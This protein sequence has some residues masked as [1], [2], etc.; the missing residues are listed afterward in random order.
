MIEPIGNKI[1]E[2]IAFGI[3]ILGSLMMLY[4]S[5]LI[6]HPVNLLKFVQPHHVMDTANNQQGI[7]RYE[8]DYCASKELFL[9]IDRQLENT[10]TGELWDVP[11]KFA[12]FSKGCSKEM[13]D[14][15]L[16]L[17]IDPGTYKLRDNISIRIN[18]LRTESYDYESESFFIG[19][20]H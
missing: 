7:L 19:V 18:A 20:Y 13:Y 10:K 2:N 6:L 1:I 15:L 17:K 9:I 5:Y 4:I 12:H 16:P 8:V 3:T 14:L 11:D